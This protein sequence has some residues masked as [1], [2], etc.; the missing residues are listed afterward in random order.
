MYKVAMIHV[1]LW[2]TVSGN[3]L[4]ED[5]APS[6]TKKAS[7]TT[8]LRIPIKG[9]IGTDFTAG[10]MQHYLRLAAKLRPT[11]IILEIDTPGGSV[12][13]AEG[14]ID[15]IIESGD[16]RY[17]AFVRK[18]L[19]AGAAIS[20]ACREIY[21]TETATLGAAVSYFANRQGAPV[22]LPDDV[23]EKFQ[24]AWRAV[25][26]KAAQ[27]GKHPAILAEAMVDPE[28]ALTI[29]KDKGRILLER[30]G[31]GKE[32]KAK[33]RILTLTAQEAVA[34]GLAR[35]IVPSLE[36]LSRKLKLPDWREVTPK[37]GAEGGTV[38]DTPGVLYK[39]LSDKATELRLYDGSLT[40]FQKKAAREQWDKWF[41]KSG[42]IGRQ[43]SWVLTLREARLT[44]E[45]IRNTESLVK[46]YQ[47]M[48]KDAYGYSGGSLGGARGNIMRS[49]RFKK[50]KER[51]REEAQK[52]QEA[53]KNLKAAK[54]CPFS[55]DA[56]DYSGRVV[57]SA[58]ASKSSSVLLKDLQKYEEIPLT[59]KIVGLKVEPRPQGGILVKVD[60]DYCKAGHKTERPIIRPKSEETPEAKAARQLRTARTYSGAGLNDKAI[61]I[62]KSILERYPKTEAAKKAREALKKLN[63]KAP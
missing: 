38:Q 24:S 3:V 34:C 14:I 57:V 9:V 44:E 59:G 51:R 45:R 62:L 11:V 26:R 60:M 32:I 40:E 12:S 5:A 8:Y 36:L 47:K 53:R 22:V 16:Y 1:L 30:N 48:V 63:S 19:S 54:A 41:K 43:V 33:G 25:C 46:A 28:F 20:L 6:P 18:S 2:A 15:Q 21:M 17:V 58:W 27:H 39:A 42:F 13:N 23:A 4:A 37:T 31:T 49:N 7:E 35:G 56:C 55:V 10:S 52:L 29:R 50:S 61:A